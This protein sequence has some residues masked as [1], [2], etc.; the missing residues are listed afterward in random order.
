MNKKFA[1]LMKSMFGKTVDAAVAEQEKAD[2]AAADKA[3]KAAKAK[4]KDK[5][6]PK[7]TAAKTG[8]AAGYDEL[9]AM[10]K[11]L[12]SKVEK[13]GQP[14]D[15]AEEEEVVV[16][17][18]SPAEMSMEDRMKK[19]EMA[20]AKLLERESKEDEVPVGDEEEEE[21]VEDESEEEVVEDEAEEEEVEDEGPKLTGDEKSRV[22]ILAP[23]MEATSK[24]FKVQALKTAYKTSDGKAAIDAI[25]GGKP[26]FTKNA[27]MLFVAASE[28]LKSKRSG[29]LAP[30]K[31]TRDFSSTIFAEEGAMTA[32]K[33][34]ELNS[35]HYNQKK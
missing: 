14:Q 2:K 16:D 7:V 12:M 33:M 17:E 24:D 26:D 23:G 13:M 6:A 3:A 28:V 15:E 25:C 5:K 22:E 35:K 29:Q 34:N 1:E 10:C 21:V 31:K 27:E 30:S 9:V 18:E 8:D 20:V 4:A 11:D 32:E 19:L